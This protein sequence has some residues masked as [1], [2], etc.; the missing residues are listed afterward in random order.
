MSS[1]DRLTGALRA[2]AA[3][4]AVLGA[5]Q[6]VDARLHAEFRAAAAGARAAARRVRLVRLA[7][8]AA[9]VTA[10]GFPSW[11]LSRRSVQV[12]IVANAGAPGAKTSEIVTDFMPLPYSGVPVSNAQIVRLEVPRSA[13]VSFG[14]TPPDAPQATEPGDTVL[15][16]VVVG[17]DGLARAVRFVRS[18]P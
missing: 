5:S 9:L 13:L 4:D 17:D 16:D 18:G 14:L 3:E 6:A 15:A 1:D 7:T 12:S 2:M 8:A 10:I 11:R